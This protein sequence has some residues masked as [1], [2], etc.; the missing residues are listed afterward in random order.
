LNYTHIFS[1]TVVN[2]FVFNTLYY[3]AIFGNL[4]A[5][6]SLTLFPGNIAF[7]ID[8]SLTALGT[9]SG[10]PGGFAA[11]FQYPQGRKVEQWGLIDDISV[12]RG[13]H[14]FKMG[15]NFRRDDITDYTAAVQTLY[16]GVNASLFGFANDMVA[17][18]GCATSTTQVGC[19]SV[20]FNFAPNDRQPVAYYSFGAYFQDE[21]RVNTK[22]KFTL[23]L[24]A[25]RNSG[26]TCNKDCA[27]LPVTP[28]N[29]LPHGET[30]PYDQSFVTGNRTIIPGIEKVVFQPRFGVAWSPIGQNTVIRAGVGLFSDLYPGTI[31]S[32]Y[33]TNFPQVTKFN[34]PTQNATIAFDTLPPGSTAFPNSG[35]AIVTGCNT[36]FVQNYFAGGSLTTNADGTPGGYQGAAAPF[37]GCLNALGALS[38]PGLS[39]VSRNLKNPKYVEWNLEVQH[40]FGAHTVVSANYVGNHGYDGLVT[41]PDLNG[42]GFGQ[43]PATV[44]DPRVAQVSFLY[45]GTV[46]NYNGVTFSIQENN[47]HGL[48]GRF[49]YTYSHALDDL[50]NGGILPFSAITSITAQIDPY[51]LAKQYGSADEDA[52]H[53]I[54]ASY[55]YQLPFKSDN[56]LVNAAIGGWVVSG[57][58]F[59]RTGFPFTILD[60]GTAGALAGQNLAGAQIILQPVPGF[61]QRNFSNGHACLVAACFTPADFETSTDFTNPVVGR[62][63]FRGPGFLGG[64]LGVRK[65]F[66]VTE[67]IT[68]QLAL[69]AYNWL[70]HANYG[71]PYPNT[72]NGI[73]GLS[74]IPQTPPTSPYGA[75]AAAATDQ[76]IAQITGKLIF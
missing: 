14:S 41:N 55:L 7:P 26:G 18:T 50:S 51:N 34:V 4:N 19:G 59:Y 5:A 2:N 17:P 33:N 44:P 25:D 66:T 49:N 12:T 70:N 40:T 67:R 71:S 35:P 48:S 9:G 72:N 37:G 58:W 8:G 62:N 39:D 16:P 38:V 30:I 73:F 43:L 56:R 6:Q 53:Q 36:A 60:G 24:R 76:R 63:A 69:N 75:F 45:N 10:N 57:T 31:L 23:T 74:V 47:W 52:R 13:V 28:F 1:P 11:G 42:F 61:T 65:N 29:D 21:Y 32:A 64:D 68:F 3:S 22:L 20:A 15:I 54:S 46:T 27:G